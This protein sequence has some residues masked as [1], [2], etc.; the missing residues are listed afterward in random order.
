[1]LNA[2]CGKQ[3]L[4]ERPLYWCHYPVGQVLKCLRIGRF[5]EGQGAHFVVE[6]DEYDTA[7]FDKTPKFLHY[8]PRT[9]VVTSV[10]FD[11]ADIYRDLDHDSFR[12]RAHDHVHDHDLCHG[13][14]Y[15]D[16]VLFHYYYRS[17]L[18]LDI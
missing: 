7:F 18:Y 10:D 14:N 15:N 2:R 12:D 16:R 11:H 9:L 17:M 5:R 8:H 13:L 4:M 1:M 3:F 6:G